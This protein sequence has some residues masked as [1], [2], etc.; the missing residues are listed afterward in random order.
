M[1]GS[2]ATKH[3]V[4]ATLRAALSAAVKQR[5]IPWNPCTGIEL[6]PEQPPE[7]RRWTP[8]EARRFIRATAD[9]P[10]GLLF[11]IAILNGERRGEL[12]GLRRSGVD[13]ANGVLT[14]DRILL[15]L[16]GKLTDGTP[17]T[18]AGVRRV[19]LDH[20]TASCCAPTT[21]RRSWSASSRARHGLTMISSSA[22][23][24]GDHGTPITCR[25]GSGGWLARRA[26]QQSSCMRHG[27]RPT[28]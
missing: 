21:G 12:C 1:P 24:T 15:Q 28:A 23:A 17:K 9:D 10:M 3:R 22:R 13:L 19:Y 4:L 11:R 18:R 16:G 5:Q 2:A 26:Y 25:S 20:G 8:A 7:A 6:E 14:I 27:T